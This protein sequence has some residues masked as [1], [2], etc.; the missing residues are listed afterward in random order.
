MRCGAYPPMRLIFYKIKHGPHATTYTIILCH[1]DKYVNTFYKLIN[2]GQNNAQSFLQW[3]LV[4]F[5]CSS[6]VTA[7]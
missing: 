4:F 3:F 7:K 5:S 2:R 6:N 1:I